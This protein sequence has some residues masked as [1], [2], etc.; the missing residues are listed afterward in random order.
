MINIQKE[1]IVIVSLIFKLTWC[2]P[3][4]LDLSLSPIYHTEGLWDKS[5]VREDGLD[6]L[7]CTPVH[8]PVHELEI[9]ATKL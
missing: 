3:A 6:L 4:F 8:I 9:S 1:N 7:N 2:S 5:H